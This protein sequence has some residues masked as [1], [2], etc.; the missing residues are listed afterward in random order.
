MNLHIGREAR[1]FLGTSHQESGYESMTLL[2]L[3]QG[4][5]EHAENVA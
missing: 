5:D 1:R 4:D 2:L 3:L